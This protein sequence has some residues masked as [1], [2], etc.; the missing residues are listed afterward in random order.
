M[1]FINVMGKMIGRSLSLGRPAQGAPSGNCPARN[2]CGPHQRRP[3]KARP[4]LLVECLEERTVPTVLINYNPVFGPE[5]L[6]HGNG[7]HLSSPPV[8]LIFWGSYWSANQAQAST[9]QNAAGKVFAS[10]YLSYLMQYGSDGQATLGDPDHYYRNNSDPTS[11]NF[12]E[13]DITTVID[14]QF[15]A[16]YLTKS[17]N[18]IY[19]VITPPGVASSTAGA[20]GFNHNDDVPSL[21]VRSVTSDFTNPTPDDFT[22]ILSHEVAECMSDLGGGGF[23]VK[24]GENFPLTP[25][26]D[27]PQGQIGDY[28]GNSYRFRESNGAVVQPYWS[29]WDNAWVAPDDNYQILNLDP[30]VGWDTLGFHHKYDLTIQGDQLPSL[31][32]TLTISSSSGGVDVMLNGQPTHFDGFWNQIQSITVNLG[33]GNDTI[34]LDNTTSVP[35]N[36][37]LGNGT[38]T[39]N[40]T[41]NSQNFDNL[42]GNVIVNGGSGSDTLNV[43]DQAN[44]VS[45]SYDIATSGMS[46]NIYSLISYTGMNYVNLYGGLA[47]QIYYVFGTGATTTVHCGPGGSN[48]NVLG[49]TATL[50]IVAASSSDNVDLYLLQNIHGLVTIENAPQAATSITVDNSHDLTARI[51]TLDTMVPAGETLPFGVITG[52]TPAS[53]SIQ[54]QWSGT[55]AVNVITGQGNDT[56]YVRSTSCPVFFDSAGD[57]TVNVGGPGRTGVPGSVQGIAGPVSIRNLNGLTQLIVDDSGDPQ[58]KSATITASSITNLAHADI[59]YIGN[60]LASLIIFGGGGANI[61]Y[62][63]STPAGSLTGRPGPTVGL[64]AGSY[65]DY[66]EVGDANNRLDG[67]QGPLVVSG[68]A[69]FDTLDIY[70]QGSNAAHTYT[71]TSSPTTSTLARSGAAP[72]T[73][74]NTTELVTINGSNSG[75][76]SVDTYT[77]QSPAPAFPVTFQGAG[78]MNTLV[79]PNLPNTAWQI[80][81]PDSGQLGLIAFHGMQNLVGGGSSNRFQFSTLGSIS[82]TINGGSGQMNTLDYSAT[83]T[84]VAVDLGQQSASRIR[85][86]A[87]NGFSQINWLVGSSAIDNSLGGA[88]TTNLWL[89]TGANAGSV[90]TTFHFSSIET[91][92]GGTGI[93]TFRFTAAGSISGSIDGGGGGDWLDYSPRSSAV[94]V[95]LATGAATSVA[96]GAVNGARRI[97]HVFGSAGNDTLTG[98][99]LGNILIGGN[100]INMIHGGSGRSLLIGGRGTSTIIGGIGGDILIAGTTIYDATFDEAALMSILREWQRTDQTRIQRIGHLVSGGGF[101]GNNKLIWGTTVLDN[102]VAG[103]HLTGNGGGQD[104]FL[105]GPG[106]TVN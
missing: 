90:N 6:A 32:D 75:S 101:N 82:G 29:Y 33:S 5:T 54:F 73:Y 46:R 55:T 50:K 3:K 9:L 69:G 56:F 23:E 4:Q 51:G 71:L 36:I 72:I 31:D 18:A 61:F 92:L 28:E 76:N 13:G 10:A 52:M 20:G 87:A 91:L 62:V 94:T 77:V 34:N 24:A 83:S 95:N 97:Q 38:D 89:I 7:D 16:G 45:G 22:W 68:Q 98:N 26:N 42:R 67:I 35:I 14:G 64:F 48:V 44:T 40:V 57:N 21:W 27:N 81:G 17:T 37:N 59:D 39:V 58:S 65:I 63:R 80:L 93:D 100:G 104:W 103:A 43:Y 86:G 60:Q 88:N 15:D 19:V 2:G 30:V 85:A 70:D 74:D 11:G 78:T 66:I 8:Y 96:Y 25:P 47:S 106:D 79:G 102:D 84:A 99:A 105:Y 1:S 53:A 41:P 49:T 12:G